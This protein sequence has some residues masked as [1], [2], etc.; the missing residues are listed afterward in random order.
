MATRRYSVAPGAV[1]ESVVEAP[2][3][4]TVTFPIEL[5]VDCAATIVTDSGATRKISK[6]EVMLALEDIK[7]WITR[8]NWPPV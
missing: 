2:G 6:E 1:P 3:A 4:A 5:T 8:A 7:I